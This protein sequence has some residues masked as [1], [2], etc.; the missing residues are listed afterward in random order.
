MHKRAIFLDRDGTIIHTKPYIKDPEQVELI[1]RAAEGLK[2][3]SRAG[4]LLIIVTNQSGIARR[5]LNL[6]DFWRVQ[7]R[8]AQELFRQGVCLD[9][10]YFCPHHPD[11]KCSCR[12][13]Q[14]QML[15][16]AQKEFL[17]SLPDSYHIGDKWE[18]IQF[19]KNAG[20]T[21]VLVL[22]GHGKE[23]LQ[24]YTL[25]SETLICD[26]LFHAAESI[27]KHSGGI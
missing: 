10:V 25:P 18:D 13:P 26:D 3:L 16:Q 9:A 23:T 24:Q 2:L 17:I 7:K 19:A 20:I 27:L 11:E 12:K 4:Y 22:T 5:S 14:V 21:P 1:H 8:L 15:L 6:T